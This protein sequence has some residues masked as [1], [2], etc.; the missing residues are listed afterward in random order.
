MN[1]YFVNNEGV[2]FDAGLVETALSESPGIKKC[3]LAPV[4]DDCAK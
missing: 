2:K 1:K 3:A 4:Y